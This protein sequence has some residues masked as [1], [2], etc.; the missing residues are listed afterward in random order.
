NWNR[1]VPGTHWMWEIVSM[2]LKGS[3]TLLTDTLQHVDYLP[4]DMLDELPSPRVLATHMP[5]SRVPR[6]FLLE[7]CKMI[8]VVRNPWDVA[9]SY[10]NFMTKMKIFGYEGQWHGFFEL[11]LDGNV[12]YNSWFE[13][14]TDWLKGIEATANVLMVRYEDLHNDFKKEVHS[15]A[16]FLNVPVTE[17]MM[18]RL[19]VETSFANMSEK[20]ID[21]TMAVSTDGTS[22]IYRKGQCGDWLNW[23]TEQQSAELK[24]A[25]RVAMGSHNRLLRYS[26]V[27]NVIPGSTLPA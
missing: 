11:F 3:E 18:E 16:D 4:M 5:F 23:F 20:K 7:G 12:P 9:V 24:G 10:F 1:T 26:N 21:L 19:Q 8:W 13:H 15:I 14:T 25:Y 2:L 22:P 6:D 27:N 17:D